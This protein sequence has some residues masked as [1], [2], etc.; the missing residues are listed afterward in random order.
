MIDIQLL[1]ND[2]E[3]TKEKLASRGFELDAA[4]FQSLE[5]TRKVLQVKTQDLQEKRN[6]RVLNDHNARQESFVY[7]KS[8]YL[9]CFRAVLR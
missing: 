9:V 5:N 6:S 3:I 1:R 7:Y 4:T 2:I 8:N